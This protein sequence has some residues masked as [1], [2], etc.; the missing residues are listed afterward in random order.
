M[1]KIFLL[2]FACS[3]LF[4]ACNQKK[5]KET[6]AA[7]D[8]TRTSVPKAELSNISEVITRFVRAYN[9]Q[10]NQK[11]NALIHRDLGLTII[12]RPGVTDRFIRV[13]S[14]DFNQPVPAYYA[15]PKVDNSYALTFDTLP[16]FDCGTEKWSKEGFICDST[17]TA[18]S[19]ILANIAKFE[20]EFDSIAF[21][22]AR[23]TAIS[24]AEDQS[25]RVILT[26]A[27][28]LIFHVKQ[29]NGAWY[30]TLLDRAYAGC[31]A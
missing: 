20:A 3:L 30:V 25:Y 28:P 13:D 21:D 5:T 15:Y 10:D 24:K 1:K 8:S 4:S 12:Y 6:T 22:T 2:A 23:K 16:T 11:A 17:S 29:Y 31:D 18:N 7:S 27:E 14:L 26:T 9:S 19:T